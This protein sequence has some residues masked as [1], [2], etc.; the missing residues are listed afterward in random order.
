MALL[1]TT[2][3][4]CMQDDDSWDGYGGVLFKVSC[5]DVIT[6]LT[7]R[8]VRVHVHTIRVDYHQQQLIASDNQ[9]PCQYH[10]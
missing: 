10:P 8:T 9:P 6:G 5:N 4:R 2:S 1:A 7:Y 3:K